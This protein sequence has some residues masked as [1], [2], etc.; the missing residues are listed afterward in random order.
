[1][2][3]MSDQVTAARHGGGYDGVGPF[4]RTGAAART[5]GEGMRLALTALI[6]VVPF[7]AL[8]A[9]VWLGWGTSIRLTDVLL[10]AVLYT[11][12]GLGV[13]VGFHRLITHRAF[14]ARPRLRVAL[15]VAG[16]MS[17]QGDVI[18]WVATHRRH[19]AFADRPGDPHS[20][21]RYGASLF[22][23]VR[24]LA[25]AHLGWMFRNDPT[26]TGRYAPD[27]LADPGMVRVA[28]AF[29][30]LCAVSLALPFL[31]GWALSGGLRGAV[32]AFLW[33]GLVRVALLQHV[34]W[35][36]NSAVPRGRLPPIHHPALRPGDQ[37]VAASVALLRRELA[38]RPPLGPHLRPP[39]D[40]PA[41][42]RP[43]SHPDPRLRTP[44]MGHR[45]ALA[46]PQPGRKPPPPIRP[47]ASRPL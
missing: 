24:G 41:P 2:M 3:I 30:A 44:R 34:T 40:R 22:S 42:A 26:P 23:Q 25:H 46:R 12:T 32:T 16:S 7:A 28:R 13:T 31:A 39:R 33:A 45:R 21:Y 8:A 9:A 17:F 18:S 36:V 20:P 6:V 19:H 37:R 15:A 27:L 4:P 35:S 5:P 11:V 10:A 1:M 14:T 43:L 47:P 38:Q 29:P